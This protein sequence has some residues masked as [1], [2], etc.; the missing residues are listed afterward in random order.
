MTINLIKYNNI[1]KR[2]LKSFC[3]TL[4]LITYLMVSK[5]YSQENE[6][7]DQPLSY[8]YQDFALSIGEKPNWISPTISFK[9]WPSFDNEVR[10]HTYNEV[11]WVRWTIDIA[12]SSAQKRD[13]EYY[14][15]IVGSYEV[16]WDEKLLFTSG[17]VSNF[18][19]NEVPG[20]IQ[21][22]FLTPKEWITPG[23]HQITFK[24][25]SH[26]RRKGQQV[27]RH[28][29]LKDYNLQSRHTSLGSLIPS[30]ALSITLIIG[31]YF[32]TLFISE[33]ENYSHI[34][35]SFL[36]FSLFTYGVVGEWPHLIGYTYDWHY[37]KEITV[38]L[39]GLVFSIL[40]PLFFLFKHQLGSK[41]FV[42]ISMPIVAFSLNTFADI[43]MGNSLYWSIGFALSIIIMS[44]VVRKNNGNY[45]W[46][47]LGLLICFT[48]VVM[49]W[50][51]L[52]NF[53][54][55]F[56]VLV[57]FILLSNV[58][59]AH[60]DKYNGMIIK[61]KASQL[62]AQLLR[63]NIQPHFILNSLA[64]IIELVETEPD[65][66]VEFIS[67]LADE[68]RLFSEIANKPTIKL[69]QEVELCRNHLAIMGFRH[70]QNYDL[71]CSGIEKDDD[72]PTGII[73]TLLENAFTHNDYSNENLTFKLMQK[74]ENEHVHISFE[75]PLQSQ[76][77]SKFGFLSTGTGTSFIESQL[78]QC[79]G[80]RWSIS[81]AK[82]V[83]TWV[84][85]ITYQKKT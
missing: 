56:P 17:Q 47:L 28:V 58:I 84:S 78:K 68:F 54:L 85:T 25:S 44:I 32:V 33:R 29:Y 24:I 34:I 2:L 8:S 52:E 31:I 73:H 61:I 59:Q 71:I 39:S 18:K 15:S 76:K 74:K 79:C 66:S 45:W 12:S 38:G 55:I 42:I 14:I 36:C 4:L 3:F 10:K 83:N 51:D 82:N 62:E 26:H 7:D 16:F 21:T 57:I 49:N 63:R 48:G 46:E 23:T 60:R 6:F 9:D 35:F 65:Q 50:Q 22:A 64:S 75:S 40:L 1:N 77:E 13:L 70:Q 41:W 20:E 11:Y 19:E 30:L 80:D 81:N 37:I 53:F 69:T 27:F 72:I 67:A 43:N 5:S